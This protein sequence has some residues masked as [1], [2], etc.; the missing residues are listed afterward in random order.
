MPRGFLKIFSNR[1]MLLALLILVMFYMVAARLFELQIVQG[2]HFL[3]ELNV[4]G[5]RLIELNAPRGTIY[6]RFGRPLAANRTEYVVMID[7]AAAIGRSNETMNNVAVELMAL[8]R[9][10]GENYIDAFPIYVPESEDEPMQFMLG[11]NMNRE[12]RWREDMTVSEGATPE[13]A[14]AHLRGSLFDIP[15]EMSNREARDI[16]A[17]RSA[18]FM[19]RFRQTEPILFATNVSFDT[20]VAISENSDRFP[21][22]FID[23]DSVRYYP[24]G[25]YV[26]N[27]VGYLGRINAEQL[28]ALADQGYG[29]HDRIGMAGLEASFESSLRGRRGEQVVE[30]N[31]V[32]RPI[33]YLDPV[34]PVPGDRLFTTIDLE[35]QTRAYYILRDM[36]TETIIN[37]LT[38]PGAEDFITHEMFFGSMVRSNNIPVTAIIDE[39]NDGEHVTAIREFLM[40]QYRRVLYEETYGDHLGTGVDTP[41]RNIYNTEPNINELRRMFA[42]AVENIEF[43]AT[44]MLMTLYEL[45][46]IDVEENFTS[47]LLDR[48]V[49]PQQAILALL[50]ANVITPQMTGLDPSTGSVVVVEV[51]TGDV[52][53]AVGYPTFDNNRLSGPGSAEYIAR[54]NADTHSSPWINRPFME[55]RAPGS[56]FK[57]ITAILGIETGAITKNSLI[58]DGVVFTKAGRPYSRNWSQYTFGYVDVNVAMAAS[59]NYFFSEIGWRL[60]NSQ[61]ARQ[62]LATMAFIRYMSDFGLNDRSGVEI[63]EYRDTLPRDMLA[64]SSP[65]FKEFMTLRVNPNANFL[66]YGWFDGDIARTAFGQSANNYTAA[67]M[68][69]VYATFASEGVRRQ[70]RLMNRIE[71]HRGEVRRRFPPSVEAIVAAAPETFQHV[72]EGLIMVTEHRHG[73]ATQIFEGFPI[74]VAGKTGTAEQITGRPSHTSF[75]GFAPFENPQIAV[76]VIIPF[77]DTSTTRSPATQVGRDVIGAFFDMEVEPERQSVMRALTP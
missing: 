19:N 61:D 2:A 75:G 39:D 15:E 10:S 60:G 48:R 3:N 45:G 62:H 68:A 52:L 67:S 72:N 16:V 51:A 24:G 49:T 35:L 7:P 47:Y 14:M 11:G 4:T 26:S 66:Q 74:R 25:R 18:I 12:N 56:T 42:E 23:V 54:L 34:P 28:Q 32:G 36:L 37:K 20:V 40:E 69:K 76:Y 13:A 27:I 31:A 63:D 6:D 21:S 53:A 64:V 59:I 43:G 73:T 29:P 1:L 30:V 57:P 22:V 71:D 17:F 58:R 77:S 33:R 41:T 38:A 9:A 5:R 65:Q 8:L 70:M 44:H 50:R 55:A 46:I